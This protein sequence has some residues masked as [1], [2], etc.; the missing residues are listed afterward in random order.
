MYSLLTSHNA[1]HNRSRGC[2][3]VPDGVDETL[4]LLRADSTHEAQHESLRLSFDSLCF[5]L[6]QLNLL[7]Q[8][9]QPDFVSIS[10]SQSRRCCRTLNPITS[11]TIYYPQKTNKQYREGTN[12]RPFTVKLLLLLLLLLQK[13]GFCCV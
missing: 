6:K 5:L 13:P 3:L 7:L 4:N 2:D 11:D 12:Q 10:I 8:S 1:M 9:N